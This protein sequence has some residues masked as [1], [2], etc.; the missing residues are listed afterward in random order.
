MN[1]V[2]HRGANRPTNLV[3]VLDAV[4]ALARS[5][6]AMAPEGPRGERAR[7]ALDT[8]LA[9]PA[10]RHAAELPET[11]AAFERELTRLEGDAEAVHERLRALVHERHPEVLRLPTLAHWIEGPARQANMMSW[12]LRAGSEQFGRAQ[13]SLEGRETGAAALRERIAHLEQEHRAMA[14]EL[15][16]RRA[17]SDIGLLAAGIAHDFN[18]VLQT[19][20]GQATLV[21]ARA[22]ERDTVAM[23]KVLDAAHRASEMT[24]RLLGWVRHGAPKPEPCDVNALVGE[25]LDLLAPSSPVR[26]LLER[27]PGDDLPLAV[28]DPVEL[29]RVVLNLVI[30]AWEAIGGAGGTVTVSTGIADRDVPAVWLEVADD[31]RGMDEDTLGRVF[32]PF[33]S[34]RTGGNGLGLSVVRGIVEHAGGDIAVTSRPGAGA[35]F[36]V[37]LPA[38]R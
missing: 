26:V 14:A 24:Q 37:T 35:A 19:I 7:R 13:S 20:T 18:N 31:G 33:F 25:V 10:A 3:E 9:L 6:A 11:F 23:E 34:T 38:R 30:N 4:P 5:L 17:L 32:E 28:A 2:R 29:R 22:N 1:G 27:R 15:E 21:R 8:L 36:R 16:R 12:L